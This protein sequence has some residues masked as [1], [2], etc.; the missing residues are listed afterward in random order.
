MW[1]H[2]FFNLVALVVVVIYAHMFFCDRISRAE[3]IL[4]SVLLAIGFLVNDLFAYTFSL[5]IFGIWWIQRSDSLLKLIP[6][7]PLILDT[8]LAKIKPR[9]HIHNL[10][11]S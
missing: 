2:I 11:H 5:F 7:N 1:A 6:V 9:S 8:I 3:V 4:A 10:I